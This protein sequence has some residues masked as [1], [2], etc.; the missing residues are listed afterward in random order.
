MSP[1]ETKNAKSLN[2]ICDFLS[3]LSKKDRNPCKSVEW[4]SNTHISIQV[5]CMWH[6]K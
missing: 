3:K 6:L 4:L 5:T 2:L 1:E